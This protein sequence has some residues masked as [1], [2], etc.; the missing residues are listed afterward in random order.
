MWGMTFEKSLRMLRVF[1]GN[2]LDARTMGEF[3]VH[4]IEHIREDGNKAVCETELADGKKIRLT[5]ERL[6]DKNDITLG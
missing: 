2:K 4:A 5:V 1:R 6:E 3:L